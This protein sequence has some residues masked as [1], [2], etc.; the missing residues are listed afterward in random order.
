MKKY[1]TYDNCYCKSHIY[2]TTWWVEKKEDWRFNIKCIK[3]EDN[4]Y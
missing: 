3:G 1:K 4:K 2:I